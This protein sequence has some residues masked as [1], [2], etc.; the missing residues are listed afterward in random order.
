MM[1]DS[2]RRIPGLIITSVDAKPAAMRA[3]GLEAELIQTRKELAK[4]RRELAAETVKVA[5]LT[6]TKE[7]MEQGIE[8][9]RL[10]VSKLEGEV[11]RAKEVAE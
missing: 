6:R 2:S 4:T 7:R 9:W 8:K 1:S 3:E 5:R 11:E 10:L